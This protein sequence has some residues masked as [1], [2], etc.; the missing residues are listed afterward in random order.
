MVS[1]NGASM[2]LNELRVLLEPIG[3]RWRARRI[4]TNDQAIT[5]LNDAYPGVDLN[6]Q[7]YSLMNDIS[8]F[9]VVCGGVVKTLGK[10][11]CSV[12]CRS[13][14]ITPEKTKVRVAKARNTCI[15]RIGVDNHAKLPSTQE[16]R[17]R[18]MLDIHGAKVSQKSLESM[19]KRSPNLNLKGRETLKERYNVINPGQLPDHIDKCKTTNLEKYGSESYHTSHLY[20][21]KCKSAR[22]E[23]YKAL[24][25][26][27]ATLLSITVDDEKVQTYDSPNYVI[28]FC[29]NTCYNVQAVPSETFRWRLRNYSTPCVKCS[30]VRKGSVKETQIAEYI[31]SLS[32][33]VQ[34]HQRILGGREIDIFIPSR[35]IGIEFH[36]LYWHSE[37]FRGKYYH[38]EKYNAASSLGIKLI[39]IFED[40]WDTHQYEIKERLRELLYNTVVLPDNHQLS[41]AILDDVIEITVFNQIVSFTQT[42]GVWVM[43]AQPHTTEYSITN[44]FRYF[45]R[46]FNPHA[47]IMHVDHRWMSDSLA[48]SLNFDYKSSS[49][50]RVW[51][52]DRGTWVR[53]NRSETIKRLCSLATLGSKKSYIRENYLRIWDCGYSTWV[54]KAT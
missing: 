1:G 8:P 53:I 33:G 30:G 52:I 18:T 20:Q 14:A 13:K 46:E 5:L 9:C 54:W 2:T 50:P 19:R 36:G 11:T 7:I 41:H 45:V 10:T 16:K 29:C 35:N 23:I 37:P 32:V 49:A 22:W 17:L 4:R 43:K 27:L 34:R 21:Q 42:M 28:S 40:E 39:Q 47:V 12:S 6:M 26:D 31:T 44:A 15:E 51:Y 3:A 38:L 25:G 48:L 24:C